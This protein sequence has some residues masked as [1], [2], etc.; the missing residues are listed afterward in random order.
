M[1][2]FGWLAAL[3][4]GFA[5]LTSHAADRPPNILFIAADDLGWKDVGSHGSDI[6]TP[7]P[8][9]L[10]GGGVRLEQFYAQP[11]SLEVGFK[12]VLHE[13]HL[14]PAF[15]GEELDLNAER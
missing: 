4:T 2:P 14:P 9:Q 7:H 15:P 8:D 5:A 6:Q 3:L 11:M 1:K 10:A 13:F 12:S